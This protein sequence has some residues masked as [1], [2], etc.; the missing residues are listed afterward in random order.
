MIIDI[1]LLY[2][3][4]HGGLEN[5]IKKVYNGLSKKVIRLGFF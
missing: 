1:V 3:L 4:G 2:A 5:V